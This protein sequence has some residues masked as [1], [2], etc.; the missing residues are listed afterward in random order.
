MREQ[1]LAPFLRTPRRTGNVMHTV[2]IATVPLIASAVWRFGMAA[3]WVI[4]LALL[5]CFVTDR[6]CRRLRK[7]TWSAG[8]G[9]ATVTALL[10]ALSLPAGTPPVA[11]IV[12]SVF[13]IAV[14]KE[15]FGG[16]GRNL[17]NPAMAARAFLMVTYPQTMQGYALPDAVTTAT[18]L[19][20]GG[21]VLSMLFGQENGSI[22]ET[23]VLL[24]LLGGGYLLTQGV[25]RWQI[26]FVSLWSFALTV[27][28]GGGD[29]WLTGDAVTHTLS[30]GLMFAVFFIATDYT[31]KP[32]TPRGEWIYAVLFGVLTALIRLYG[33]YP[34]GVCFSTLTANMLTP[35]IERL[36]RPRVYGTKKRGIG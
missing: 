11:V 1:L 29:G 23:S 32:A 26:P 15:L 30:G 6:I 12:G 9:S 31:T 16:I 13:A 8:D 27:W 25:I 33:R 2:S 5:S 35:L 20:T 18:P 19:Q 28:I 34:E 10:L 21:T 4:A 14:A 24:I 7:G 36:T 17:F 3:V 22:G